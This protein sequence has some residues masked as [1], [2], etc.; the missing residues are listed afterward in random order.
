[1]NKKLHLASALISI[2]ISATILYAEQP[3]GS[4]TIDRIA[5]I[6]YPSEQQWSPDGKTVAFLWDAAGKQDLYMVRPGEQPVALTNFPVDPDILTSDIGTFEWASSD[7]LIFS[8]DNQ[9]WSVSTLTQK[10][11]PL[12][13]F[14]GVNTFSLSRNKQQIVFVQKG[15][16]WVASLKA[17][18]RRRLTHMPEGL[19]IWQLSFSPDSRYVAFDAGQHQTVPEPLPYNGN[20]VQVMRSLNWDD[21]IGIISVYAYAEEPTWIPVATRNYGSTAM[22][23][24]T[25]PMG[26]SI[27]HVEYS[28]DHQTMEIKITSVS[29]DTHTLWK[30]HDPAWISPA[31]GAGD[32]TSPDG[33]W[34]AFISD[35]SGWPHLYVIPTD[36]T[37][38]AQAKQISTG[39][40]GDGYAAWS[41]DSKRIAFAHSAEGNQMERFI[42]IATIPNG[43][44]EPVVTARGVNRNPSFSPDGST[45]VYERSAVEH[46]L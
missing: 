32:A 25:G 46:P 28:A 15:D 44:I 8:K 37:S 14:Q 4:I 16:V 41:P 24:A 18:T 3:R 39:N 21:R 43:Q 36:A 1:V 23:W 10:P 34:L 35:R 20:L 31:D 17:K 5:D 7:S 30:D 12:P 11:E 27:V 9:L 2:L 22:Q 19:R 45:L 40:F 29:G 42:S 13:G 33:K 26:P 38:E 6:K